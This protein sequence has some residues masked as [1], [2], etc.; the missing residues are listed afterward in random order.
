MSPGDSDDGIEEGSEGEESDTGDYERQ[1]DQ[2]PE[3]PQLQILQGHLQVAPPQQQR[4]LEPVQVPAQQ[5]QLLNAMIPSQRQQQQTP[6]ERP[7]VPQA[8]PVK[9]LP[10]QQQL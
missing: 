5:P 9:Y 7:R 2:S 10:Q 8:R 4:S 1:P 6:D 3:G